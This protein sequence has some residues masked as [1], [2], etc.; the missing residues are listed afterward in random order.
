MMSN[1]IRQQFLACFM[2]AAKLFELKLKNFING[3]AQLPFVS[4]L[5]S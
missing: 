1:V 2:T 5:K 3:A 4:K